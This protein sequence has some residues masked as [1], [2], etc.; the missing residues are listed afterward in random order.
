MWAAQRNI[1]LPI[2]VLVLLC[3]L[4]LPIRPS[5]SLQVNS[6]GPVAGS[7]ASSPRTFVLVLGSDGLIGSALTEWLHSRSLSTVLVHNRSHVDLRDPSA[8]PLYL[9]SLSILPS[10]LTFAFFLACEVGGSKFLQS[11]TPSTRRAIL[12]HN[13]ALYQSVLPFLSL[14][15]IPFLFTSSYLSHMDSPYGAIKRVGEQLTSLHPLGRTVRLWNVYG[16]ERVGVKAHV[17]TDWTAACIHSGAVHSLT[18]GWELRQFIHAV[19]VADAL[20]R[21]M[22]TW[23]R[24][25]PITDLSSGQWVQMRQVARVVEEVAGEGGGGGCTVDFTDGVQGD[26]VGGGA[27]R[28]MIH[29]DMASTWWRET[30]WTP[31][32]DLTAGIHDLYQ[33]YGGDGWRRAFHEQKA[34]KAETPS[35]STQRSTSNA[36]AVWLPTSSAPPFSVRTGAVVR[37]E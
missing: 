19:D 33:H 21:M 20:G 27:V 1:R 16:R 17:L 32:T 8:L 22:G 9:S 2:L 34:G 11:S 15:S 5:S 18:D 37:T 7:S 36:S 14:H 29:P 13:L 25:D 10:S 12:T 28:E 4:F 35:L 26:H 3:L 6:S 31:R 30:G 24:M 23:T